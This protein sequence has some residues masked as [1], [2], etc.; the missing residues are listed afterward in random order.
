ME[1][2][3]YREG[4]GRGGEGRGEER[5]ER[6]DFVLTVNVRCSFIL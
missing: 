1:G 6:E 3:H 5:T 2:V 4:Q